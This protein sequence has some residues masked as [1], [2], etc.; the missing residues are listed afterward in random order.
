MR[1]TR[2]VTA[3]G[4]VLACAAFAE[5]GKAPLER[6]APTSDLLAI[7]VSGAALSIEK[8]G[9]ALTGRI[10][11]TAG[12]KDDVVWEVGLT[13]AD[14]DQAT[15]RSTVLHSFQ[16]A[17]GG[18]VDAAATWTI[19]FDVLR[20]EQ[21]V[22]VIKELCAK[23]QQV[24]PVEVAEL[25]KVLEEQV[26]ADST[27][28]AVRTLMLKLK[29]EA[30]AA[31]KAVDDAIQSGASEDVLTERR[32]EAQIAH[33][34]AA[35]TEEASNKADSLKEEKAKQV[36]SLLSGE[37]VA[38]SQLTP[39]EQA[40][41]YQRTGLLPMFFI[42]KA[43]ARIGAQLFK[44]W[45]ETTGADT[46]MTRF[47]AEIGVLAGV[48]LRPTMLLGAGVSRAWTWEPGTAGSI[49]ENQTV[50]GETTD[51]PTLKCHDIPL[52]GPTPSVNWKARI[53]WNQYLTK[54]LAITPNLQV[55][56]KRDFLSRPSSIVV[57]VPVFWRLA[58][59]DEKDG[60]WLVL[61]A[62]GAATYDLAKEEFTPGVNVFLA[63]AFPKF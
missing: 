13:G 31:V 62:S 29:A 10:A 46:K 55:M 51:P 54:T 37:C 11:G 60:K 57:E 30:A 50:G 20:A 35:R 39:D 12:K 49:C 1:L 42:V 34:H 47:P 16:Q 28:A 22:D 27:A 18:T 17:A 41:V 52:S 44:Y 56:F 14:V 23:R 7:P 53:E 59:G 6:P 32:Q 40:E 2:L 38:L 4:L 3:V 33:T 24:R 5:E 43:Q 61:G 58:V 15:Q 26:K 19:G 8:D 9:K 63:A 36:E 45:D 25:A 48:Q 21:Q